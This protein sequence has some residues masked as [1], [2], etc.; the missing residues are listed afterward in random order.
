MKEG[1]IHNR[2]GHIKRTIAKIKES[3]DI[4]PHNTDVILNFKDFLESQDLSDDRISRYLYTWKMF[5]EY[6]DWNIDHNDKSLIIDLIGDINKDNIREKQL[7]EYTKMEYKKALRKMYSDYLDSMREDIDGDNMTD[8]FS[9]TV[10]KTTPDPD[11]LPGPDTV[12]ELVAH[13]GNIRNQAF[14]MTLWSSAGRIGEVLGLKWK[15]LDFGSDLVTVTF[16]ETKT[17]DNRKVPLHV[18]H[19]YL[20][21]HKETEPRGGEREAFVFRGRRTDEQL[22]HN[23]GYNII[24]RARERSGNVPDKIDTNPHAFRKGRATFLAAQGMNQPTLCEF[25]GWV[26]GSDRL[27]TYIGLA[28]ADVEDGVRELVGIESSYK[29]KSE[30]DLEPV[31]CHDC[32]TWNKWDSESCSSCGEAL[33]TSDLF[34]KVQIEEKTNQFMGEIISS[35][36]KFEPEEINEKAKEFVQE[37]FNLE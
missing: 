2:K 37:E 30:Q 4:S 28:E 29:Q 35:E 26:Q 24:K 21:R 27:A 32:K 3:E 15:D 12:R 9:M 7:S 36:T 8:F 23:G 34:Q 1:D 10:Q 6:V 11:K 14:I 17:G 5:G 13:A 25:G 20:K 16:R 22:S 31:Q 33:T 18:G 19:V